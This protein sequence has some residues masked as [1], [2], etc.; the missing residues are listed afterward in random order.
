M[1]LEPSKS[2]PHQGQRVI[3]PVTGLSHSS[4]CSSSTIVTEVADLCCMVF[5]EFNCSGLCF[6]DVLRKIKTTITTVIKII[7][8]SIGPI[9]PSIF[10]PKYVEMLSQYLNQDHHG[11]FGGNQ[12]LFDVF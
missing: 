8:S 9:L 5:L 4:Q 12:S 3:F 10:S 11:L 6:R 7:I 1:E 2:T